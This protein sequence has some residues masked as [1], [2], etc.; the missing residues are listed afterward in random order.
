MMKKTI[1]VL[2]AV[3]LAVC[4]LQAQQAKQK[5]ML[6]LQIAALRTYADYAAKGYKAVKNGLNFI[7]GAKK[8][9]VSLHSGYFT[10]LASVN[11][12]VKNY[13]RAAEIITL[14]IKIARSYKRTMESLHQDDLFH[15]S[16][17]DYIE[18]T[19]KRLLDSCNDSLDT[20]LLIAAST[21]LEVKDDERIK[22]IDKL[23][24]AAQEDYAFCEKFSGELKILALSKAKEKN[25]ARQAGALFGL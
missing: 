19:F 5:R 9:E 11:P 17:L 15:G 25:D 24:E 1:M 23:Y 18:R 20:L 2:A 12:K 10:S 21:S 14:Q 7:S 4:Q 8:G 22:R 6:L 13:G 3:C 16:E